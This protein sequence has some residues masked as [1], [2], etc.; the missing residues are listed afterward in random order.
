MG[1]NMK[2]PSFINLQIAL[3][4]ATLATNEFVGTLQSIKQRYHPFIYWLFE[5]GVLK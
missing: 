3:Q 4:N 2:N 1:I 5:I